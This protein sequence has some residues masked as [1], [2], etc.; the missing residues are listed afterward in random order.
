MGARND[1][2]ISTGE[3]VLVCCSV[4]R[5]RELA[6]SPHNR[7]SDR[8]VSCRRGPSMFGEG[9]LVVRSKKCT[10]QLSPFSE[11]V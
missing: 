7:R 6:V 9:A 10:F 3:K 8:S 1:G 2:E 11:L 5:G 4:N